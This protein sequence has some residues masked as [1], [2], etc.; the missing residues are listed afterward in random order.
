MKLNV[1]TTPKGI[2]TT[3]E[4]DVLITV[5]SIKPGTDSAMIGEQLA[6]FLHCQGLQ[7]ELSGRAIPQGNHY[8][9]SRHHPHH[10]PRRRCSVNKQEHEQL[11]NIHRRVYGYSAL[12]GV[13]LNA[14]EYQSTRND[15]ME[16]A[17]IELVL[18]NLHYDLAAQ[19]EE[20]EKMLEAAQAKHEADWQA[21][22]ERQAEQ[23]RKEWIEQRV[24]NIPPD[25]IKAF[26]AVNAA[27][28]V[29]SG[30]DSQ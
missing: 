28:G 5:T 18:Q 2:N 23:A 19:C 4:S 9:P 27:Y 17:H 30:E 8:P 15:D 25:V 20:L 12:I 7:V 3:Y 24:A 11:S 29:E 13:A 1:N 14:L 16:T 10:Y 21:K 22:Q 26:K 6:N